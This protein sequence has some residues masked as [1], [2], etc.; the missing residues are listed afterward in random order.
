MANVPLLPCPFEGGTCDSDL[1]EIVRK[2]DTEGRPGIGRAFVQCNDCG[3]RGPTAW[4]NS[5]EAASD[6]ATYSWNDRA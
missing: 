6:L 4:A 1:L 3:A 2:P 5:A